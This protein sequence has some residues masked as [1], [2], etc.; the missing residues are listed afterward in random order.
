VTRTLRWSVTGAVAAGLSAGC[1]YYNAIWYAKRHANDARRL[2]Q[3]GQPSDARA[4]WAQAAAKTKAW[5]TD[6]AFVLRVE[7]L[8]YSG[9]CR[10][11]AEQ[12]DRAR[13]GVQ[14]ATR[15]ERIDLADAEC[16]L[17]GGDP[18]H[19]E[20]ALAGPLVSKNADRRSRAEY[21]AGRTAAVRLEY[22][23]ATIHFQRSREPGAAA[24]ALV[25][26][27]QR[28]IGRAT[29]RAD[30]TPIATELARLLRGVSGTDE[31]SRVLE[32]LTAVMRVSE[33]AAARFRAAEIVRD[34]LHAPALAG[35]LFLEAAA[36]D[37]TSLY[38]PKA[39][40]AALVVLPDRRDSLAAL[41]DSRYA[42]S[43]YTRVFHGEPSVAYAAAED[44]LARELGVPG[45]GT[46]AR[47]TAVPTGVLFD[48]PVPGRRGPRLDGPSPR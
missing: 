42:A 44:S 19:A 23:A 15:R 14:D 3:H 48:A 30:L 16:A 33:T 40:I 21:L 24:R 46:G 2:E 20:A 35:Q 4:Q 37:S 43:P 34:S 22:D 32:F 45:G 10:D 29:Q 47:S 28:L 17:A 39:L 26:E 5:K 38:A 8:A 7:G 27:Q 25:S 13:A 9:A 11:A 41:L 6:D 18:V 12:I 36:A 1:S 31:A